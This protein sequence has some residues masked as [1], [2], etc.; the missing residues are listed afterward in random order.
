MARRRF[1]AEEIGRGRATLR[2]QEARHLTRVLPAQIG[3]RFEVSDNRSLYLAE[4]AALG[5]DQVSFRIIEPV[6]S[7]EPPTRLA[8]LISLIKFDRFEWLLEK[9]A[10]LGVAT[11]MSVQAQRS[12]K[13]LNIATRKRLGRWKMIVRESSQQARR[14]H[15][16][17][18]LPPASFLQALQDASQ[19]RYFLEEQPG[20]PP[21]LSALPV[22]RLSSDAVTLLVGPEGGW[23]EAEREHASQSRWTSVSLGPQ[24]LRAETARSHSGLLMKFAE[25]DQSLTRIEAHL[26]LR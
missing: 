13:S 17:E 10:E 20:S 3:Q 18:L 23:T 15:L 12:Q 5:K 4:V 6:P 19:Y 1:F 21:L 8:L 9:A 26:N 16:P 14:A 7:Q 24:V 25:L 22:R 2:G 11:I